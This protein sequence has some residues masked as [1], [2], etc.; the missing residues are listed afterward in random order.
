MPPSIQTDA[1]RLS[2]R[3]LTEQTRGTKEPKPFVP[4]LVNANDIRAI[5]SAIHDV[6]DA[7]W[8]LNAETSRHGVRPKR[9][10]VLPC[11]LKTDRKN[12]VFYVLRTK[13]GN[14]ESWFWGGIFDG[15]LRV[16]RPDTAL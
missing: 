1:L 12:A 16:V 11:G 6:I 15:S 9:G 8:N 14:L 2:Q 13:R 3:D 7:S 10:V 4:F 5:D